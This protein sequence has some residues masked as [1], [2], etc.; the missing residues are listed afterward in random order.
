[1]LEFILGRYVYIAVMLLMVI[2]IYGMMFKRN[3]VKKI[4]GMAIF[5]TAIFMFYIEGATKTGGSVPIIDPEIGASAAG[6]VNPL[7]HALILTG[8]V[9][10]ISLTGVALAFLISLY[11]SYQSLDEKTIIEEMRK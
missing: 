7:P 2:G 8:I 4:I 9:V 10:A 5:Q 1:M 11:R 3:L 6:Y